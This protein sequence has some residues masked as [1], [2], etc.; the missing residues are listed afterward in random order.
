MWWG[1]GRRRWTYSRIVTQKTK[2]GVIKGVKG[3]GRRVSPSRHWQ[4]FTLRY[5]ATRL[6]R[7]LIR[8][9][10]SNF[11]NSFS[12]VRSLPF[13]PSRAVSIRI[14][15]QFLRL[16][17]RGNLHQGLVPLWACESWTNCINRVYEVFLCTLRR[18]M[19]VLFAYMLPDKY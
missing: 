11:G 5:D 4:R 9:R 18:W 10:M 15:L 2:E 8:E 7:N 6:L 12:F 13:F 1:T 16:A 3:K 14:Y 17:S 19:G